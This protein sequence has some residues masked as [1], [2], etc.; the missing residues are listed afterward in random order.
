MQALRPIFV[1]G[2]GRCGT[3]L[4]GSMIGAR[5]DVAA[6]PEAKFLAPLMPD[7]PSQI[8]DAEEILKTISRDRF[9]RAWNWPLN[10]RN[11]D[12]ERP[13]TYRQLVE[14]LLRLHASDHGKPE[15]DWF[16]EH[17]PMNLL[18]TDRILRHFPDAK[19]INMIRDGRAY[20][21]S[22]IPLSWG[23]ET[24]IEAAEAWSRYVG[25]GFAASHFA[26]GAFLHV[27]YE[28]LL[29]EPEAKM[30]EIAEFLAMDWS[31][32]LL[33]SRND[34]MPEWSYDRSLVGRPLDA[35]RK[36][37][38]KHA[39]SARQIEIFESISGDLLN[40]LGYE[41][42]NWMPAAPSPWEQLSSRVNSLAR[43]LYHWPQQQHHLWRH[44]RRSV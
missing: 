28:D 37:A 44:G 40:Q 5:S 33:R 30:R 25:L 39:L 34:H 14:W 12:K 29:A 2:S 24:V 32:D 38:W 4:V 23:P 20:A 13:W 27:R 19:F 10:D 21:S 41:C 18:Y 17:F 7:N 3:T 16:V 43:K 42:A 15:V 1:V 8:V 6:H 36:D 22:V 11:L 26:P 9:F 35:S 31:P